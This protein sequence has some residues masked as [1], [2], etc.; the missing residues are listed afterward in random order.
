MQKKVTVVIPCFNQGAFLKDA[1][2][3]LSKCDQSLFNTIIV[4]DGSTDSYTIEFLDHLKTE[5]WNIITQDNK[6]LGEARN[7]GIRLSDTPYILPLDSDNMIRPAYLEMGIEVMDRNAGVAVVYG[8]AAYFG[9]KSGILKSGHFNLQ[10]LM[11]AN[12]IDACALI[13]KSVIEEVGYYDNMEIMGY[14]DWDLWLR[15]AF[16]GHK[17]HYIE[18]VM[19]DYRVTTHSMMK[20]LNQSI[21]RQNKIEDYFVRKYADKLSFE[22][23]F[24]HVVFQIKKNPV[25]F[26]FRLILKKYFPNYYQKRIAGGKMYRGYLYNG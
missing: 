21:V 2:T 17:F 8:D 1:L 6:G 25:K 7:T 9:E 13:R 10:L 23:V 15:I 12:R 16:R 5:G 18:E 26:I 24:N 3:S 22:G 11:L 20:S 14:E 4:N 19:F